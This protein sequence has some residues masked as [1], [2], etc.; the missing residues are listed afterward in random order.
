MRF[1]KTFLLLAAVSAAAQPTRSF[2]DMQADITAAVLPPGL[3]DVGLDQKL[4][5]QAPLYLEFRDEDGQQAPLSQFF[6]RKPVILA[7]VYY[8]CPMLCT[9]ILNGLVRSLRG[10]SLESGRDF[11]VVSVSIDPTETP[12][13]AKRKRDE[14]L[15]RYAKSATG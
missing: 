2:R 1:R 12:E 9:Q 3:R 7:L 10:M 8:Q 11:E 13:L 14:Y 4:N 15:R 5:A 6:G